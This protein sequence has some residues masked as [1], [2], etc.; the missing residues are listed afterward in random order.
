LLLFSKSSKNMF[1]IG[2]KIAG[3]SIFS[4]ES[5]GIFTTVILLVL[6]IVFH[7]MLRVLNDFG[8]CNKWL[9]TL[10]SKEKMSGQSS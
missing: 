8:V 9:L 3:L 6:G 5:S 10:K 4:D 7:R 2:G 1:G